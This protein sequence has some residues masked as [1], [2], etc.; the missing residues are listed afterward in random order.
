MLTLTLLGL[1]LLLILGLAAPFL[2]SERLALRLVPGGVGGLAFALGAVAIIRLVAGGEVTEL[3]LPLGLPWIGSHFR[4]DDLSC[5]FLAA[6]NLATAMI[7]LF[8]TGYARRQV[9]PTR[10]LAAL[11]VFL[12]ACNLVL[13]ANDAFTF[14][15]AWELMAVAAWLLVL[16][17]H[18]EEESRRGA[19][20]YLVMASISA[21]LLLLAFGTLAGPDGDYRFSALREATERPALTTLAVVLAIVATGAKAGLVPL[22][23]WLPLAVPAAPS[24]VSAL[25]SGVMVKVA[26]YALARILLDLAGAPAWWWGVTLIVVGA[27]SALIGVLYALMQT[28]LKRLL[29]YSTIG[30]AGII[31]FAF[32]LSLSFRTYELFDLS[33]LALAAALAHVLNHAFFKSLLF[34]GAGAIHEATGLR[35][36]E[37]LGGL[38]RRMPYT[39]LFMLLGALG[40]AGLPP[41]NGFVSEWLIFQALFAASALQDNLP[42]LIV[43]IAGAA[44]ALAAALAAAG[45]VRAFGFTFLGRP[46]SDEAA[47]AVEPHGSMA[48]GLALMAVTCLLLGIVPVLGLS[49]AESAAHGV[50]GVDLPKGAVG[51]VFLSPLGTGGAAYAGLVVFLAVIGLA[52]ATRALLGRIWPERRRRAAAWGGGY[53]ESDMTAQYTASGFAQP[54]RRVFGTAAFQ[55]REAVDMPEPGST[56]AARLEVRLVDPAWDWVVLPL[57]RALDTATLRLDALQFLS[58]RHYLSLM[59]AALVILLLI[60]AATQQ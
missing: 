13:V 43:P 39:S 56:R 31:V 47:K 41:L 9:R 18:R 49:L 14:V 51:W 29:A 44:L 10:T 50:I 7:M 2:R 5:F 32:G 35:D 38:V 27:A 45:F 8:A 58:I 11:P 1:F 22:H 53:P 59:F 48:A 37:K 30:N 21:L 4:L 20:A 15:L 17:D 24:H 25:L 28:D 3:S 60:V 6:I 26:L 57:K 16:A 12:A 23:V 19:F 36:I 40:A 46:R 54:L 52:L 33:A 42:R 34:C 55:A